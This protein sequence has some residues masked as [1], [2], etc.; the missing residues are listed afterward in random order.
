MS[1]PVLKLHTSVF[2][3]PRHPRLISLICSH[4]MWYFHES[5][6]LSGNIGLIFTGWLNFFIFLFFLSK[7]VVR[8]GV[9]LRNTRERKSGRHLP[10][11][12][13]LWFYLKDNSPP[14]QVKRRRET[15]PQ[16]QRMRWLSWS[17]ST[18]HL[19]MSLVLSSQWFQYE[20]HVL[21][22]A[23]TTSECKFGWNGIMPAAV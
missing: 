15:C 8:L 12:C 5:N 6:S 2:F 20:F 10:S 23:D 3:E 18:T 11:G 16:L 1:R 22:L 4:Q 9:N 7:L 14:L 19:Q 21:L 13:L 17:R